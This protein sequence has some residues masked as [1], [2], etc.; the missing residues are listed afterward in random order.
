MGNITKTS[1]NLIFKNITAIKIPEGNVSQIKDINTGNIIWTGSH[2]PLRYKRYD[3][4]EASGTQFINS[5]VQSTADYIF[6]IDFQYTSA[7]GIHGVVVSGTSRLHMG[8]TGNNKWHLGFR[9]NSNEGGTFD[10]NRH[11][12]KV[13][14]KTRE[15]ELGNYT[16]ISST[17]GTLPSG[18]AFLLFA[19]NNQG[20][21]DYFCK[22]KMYSFI[23]KNA[24][25]GK[26]VR[27]MVPVLDTNTNKFGLYD[28]VN[29]IFYGNSGT[30]DFTGGSP[31]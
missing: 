14:S 8:T 21:T 31:I 15:F 25:T 29:D 10:L 28:K 26:K 7:Q 22:G 30:G 16:G 17:S 5:N 9:G 18:R 4:I 3:Y 11:I 2:I 27:E 1:N 6:E 23:L 20:S 13:N 24:N 12:L 19:R